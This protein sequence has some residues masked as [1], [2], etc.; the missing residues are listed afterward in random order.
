MATP[1]PTFPTEK[2]AS[3][4]VYIL[5]IEHCV[6]RL[7]VVDLANEMNPEN[8]SQQHVRNVLDKVKMAHT[9]VFYTRLN[10]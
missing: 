7:T 9:H 10:S 3:N 8:A 5:K 6:M 4:S 1:L 2:Q